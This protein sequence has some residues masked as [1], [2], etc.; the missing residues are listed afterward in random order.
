M[1]PEQERSTRKSALDPS[2]PELQTTH[3]WLPHWQKGGS[4]YFVTFRTL[5]VDLGVELR[6]MVLDACRFFDGRRY[7]LLAAVVMPDHVHLLLLPLEQEP[8]RWWSLASITHSI[9]SFTAKEINRRLHRHG[10]VWMQESFDR[11]VRDETELFEKWQYI[12]NNP[13]K[14]GLCKSPSAWDALHRGKLPW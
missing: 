9:K 6:R 10:A 4:V 13:V 5:G 2:G 8:G 12:E 1:T 14:A 3:R 11:I 7:D